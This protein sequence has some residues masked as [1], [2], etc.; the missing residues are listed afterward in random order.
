MLFGKHRM[1]FYCSGTCH[2]NHSG[3]VRKQRKSSAHKVIFTTRYRRR[4]FSTFLVRS[5]DF[6]LLLSFGSCQIISPAIIIEHSNILYNI[7][8]PLN[9]KEKNFYE[10][11]SAPPP[12]LKKK[13]GGGN[14]F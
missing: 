7:E 6:L 4:C 11:V 14:I 3:L 10:E 2:V 9:K 13:K 1:G 12:H 8:I 5:I